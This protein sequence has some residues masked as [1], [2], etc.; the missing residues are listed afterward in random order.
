MSLLRGLPVLSGGAYHACAQQLHD[1]ENGVAAGGFP[2]DVELVG[3]HV[4]EV[5][6][7]GGLLDMV[8]DKSGG[9]LKGDHAIELTGGV[10]GGYQDRLAV[11]V[12]LDKCLGLF[13]LFL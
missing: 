6:Q 3:N 2:V 7:T 8:P 1:E 9:A 5:L 13:H 10:A 11:D 4:D 12:S